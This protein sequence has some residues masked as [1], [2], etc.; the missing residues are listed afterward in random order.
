MPKGGTPVGPVAS[1]MRRRY[2]PPSSDPDLPSPWFRALGLVSQPFGT[3]RNPLKRESTAL[4]SRRRFAAQS[5]QVSAP[6][7]SIADGTGDDLNKKI[8]SIG[9]AGGLLAIAVGSQALTAGATMSSGVQFESWH[10]N[11]FGGRAAALPMSHKD[12]Q[13]IV[14]TMTQIDNTSVDVEGDGQGAGD[15]FVFRDRVFND[16][17]VRVGQDNGQCTVNFPTDES[18]ISLNCAVAFTFTGAGGFRRGKIMVEGNLRFTA[19][20]GTDRLPITGGTA[21]Y[22][23]VRGQVQVIGGNESEVVFHLLR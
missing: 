5:N 20:S 16:N 2:V 13:A 1:V 12:G 14:V 10:H 17:G 15:Y 21:H 4:S 18:R 23:N 19:T 6:D 7:Q 9:L 8:L 22:K 11:P 3:E